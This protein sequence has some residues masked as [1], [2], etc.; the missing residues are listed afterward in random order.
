MSDAAPAPITKRPLTVTLLAW[1]FIVI[2][3]AGFIGHFP[4]HRPPFHPDDFWPPLL[5]IVL[6]TAGIF[7]FRGRSWARWLALAW[8]AF[9]VAISFYNSLREV[10]VHSLMLVL[11]AWILFYPAASAWFRSRRTQPL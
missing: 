6:L 9:H 1:L 4:R 10:A 5:E 3:V 8:I 2:G 7:V 11:F